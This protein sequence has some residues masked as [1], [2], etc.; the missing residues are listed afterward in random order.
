M[1][2]LLSQNVF[3]FYS[4]KKRS[5]SVILHC[6][7]KAF[8][9]RKSLTGNLK[10]HAWQTDSNTFWTR[11]WHIVTLNLICLADKA[12]N[13]YSRDTVWSERKFLLQLSALNTLISFLVS[14][15][16]QLL[17]RSFCLQTSAFIMRSG[18]LY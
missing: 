8:L 12:K 5:F 11:Q 3:L 17:V 18:T 1:Q 15:S 13:H 16:L 2:L 9:K 14:L 4:L 10:T 7:F 6:I